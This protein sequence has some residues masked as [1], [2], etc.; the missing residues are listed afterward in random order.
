M[1]G[2]ANPPAANPSSNPPATEFE[3]CAIP[4]SD[5]I[6]LLWQQKMLGFLQ[7]VETT[8]ETLLRDLDSCREQ[9]DW[10]DPQ[11][12]RIHK[13]I[14]GHLRSY[15]KKLI[16]FRDDESNWLYRHPAV[17]IARPEQELVGEMRDTAALLT[18][19]KVSR[20]CVDDL[21]TSIKDK[22]E[23]HELPLDPPPAEQPTQLPLR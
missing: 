17:D 2:P 19:I 23:S 15:R 9:A 1:S 14:E 12:Q 21:I 10:E 22:L 13:A 8:V 6:Y 18:N 16:D 3:C 7:P 20:T 11:H 4:E 5:N